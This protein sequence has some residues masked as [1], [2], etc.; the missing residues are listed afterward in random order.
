M[1]DTTKSDRAKKAEQTALI[2]IAVAAILGLIFAF[3]GASGGE[4]IGPIKSFTLLVFLA[5]AINIA[6]NGLV[7]TSVTEPS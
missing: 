3:L 2:G 6:V 7:F 5:F 4:S 1:T